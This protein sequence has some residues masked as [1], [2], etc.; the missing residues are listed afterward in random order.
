MT[1]REIQNLVKAKLRSEIDAEY[2]RKNKLVRKR[3]YMSN[4]AISQLRAIQM[5][6]GQIELPPSCVSEQN[7]QLWVAFI[8]DIP[9]ANWAHT[10]RYWI[11]AGNG[12]I[13]EFSAML[14]PSEKNPF[15]LEEVQ[16]LL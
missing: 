9:T 15:I 14:P 4:Q 1:K 2:A 13:L 8:D 6:D 10:C 7:E 3:L 12:Q 5:I 16:W 11:I